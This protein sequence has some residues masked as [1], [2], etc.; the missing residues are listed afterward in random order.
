MDIA[1]PHMQLNIFSF[2]HQL[3]GHPTNTFGGFFSRPASTF[4]ACYGTTSF[5]FPAQTS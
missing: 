5:T 4:R 3:T 1:N 2:R